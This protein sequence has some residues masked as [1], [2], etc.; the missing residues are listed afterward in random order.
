MSSISRVRRRTGLVGH[1]MLAEL[2]VVVNQESD[3]VLLSSIITHQ[4]NRKPGEGFLPY[5]KDQGFDLPLEVMQR[6][7]YEHFG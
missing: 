7:V 3:G 5:A 1:S 4:D 6:Q 2:V